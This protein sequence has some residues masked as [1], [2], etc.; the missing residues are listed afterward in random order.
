[1]FPSFLSF[2]ALVLVTEGVSKF[3]SQLEPS[4]GEA[5]PLPAAHGTCLQLNLNSVLGHRVIPSS[6]TCP[7]LKAFPFVQA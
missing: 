4:A 7:N 5:L 1:M 2:L 3:M 6:I